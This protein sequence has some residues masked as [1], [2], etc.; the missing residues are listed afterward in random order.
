MAIDSP[1]PKHNPR[2]VNKRFFKPLRRLVK[3]NY[4]RFKVRG[5]NHI[6][7]EGP[8]VFVA[9]HSGWVALDALFM[10]MAIY[11][12][13]GP[14][15]LPYIIVHDMLIKVPMTYHF[16]KDL[17]LIPADWLQYGREPLPPHINPVAIFPEGA[18]GNSKPFWKAYH[19][20][21]WKT[22]FVRLAIQR[23]AKVVPVMIVGGEEAVPVAGTIDALRPLLG[24]VAPIPLSL[25]PLPS[26]WRVQ[27]LEPVDFSGYD[28]A[29]IHD[30]QACRDIAAQVHDLVQARLQK[31]S[32]GQPLNWLSNLVDRDD[33]DDDEEAEMPGEA[34][35]ALAES[36]TAPETAA[37]KETVKESVKE[38]EQS[39]LPPQSHD[40]VKLSDALS[41]AFD[42][43]NP[44]SRDERV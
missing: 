14:N 26:R 9:N 35:E 22:G 41:D 21:Q 18:D 12:T 16:L 6:P 10:M 42:P 30:K 31:A 29:L 43:F 37:E 11:D 4:F 38:P 27:F 33:D 20:Q 19:M 25:A 23:K 39:V 17:G 36:K 2:E 44:S 8:I 7:T 5:A 32:K 1:L 40:S 13:A 3:M 15:Y 34:K 24:S 28:P